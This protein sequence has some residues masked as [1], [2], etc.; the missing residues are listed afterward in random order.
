[1][2]VN[3]ALGWRNMLYEI[4]MNLGQPDVVVVDVRLIFHKIRIQEILFKFYAL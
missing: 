2:I 3:K 1:M 4:Q